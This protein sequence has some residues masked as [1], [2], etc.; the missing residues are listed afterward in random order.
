MEKDVNKALRQIK[1]KNY[2]I[3]KVFRTFAPSEIMVSLPF[4]LVHMSQGD[5]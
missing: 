4:T 1:E 5:T 3:W 2:E